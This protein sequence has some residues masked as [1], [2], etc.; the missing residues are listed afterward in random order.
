VNQQGAGAIPTSGELDQFIDMVFRRFDEPFP[1]LSDIV[2][3]ETKD[4]S[5]SDIRERQPIRRT[6]DRNHRMG[7]L[8]HLV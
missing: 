7:L 8:D 3:C 6:Q 4:R 2:K 5:V 1:G